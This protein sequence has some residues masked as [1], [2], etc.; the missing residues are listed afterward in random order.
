M[1]RDFFKF[2][3]LILLF[4]V[5]IIFNNHSHSTIILSFILHHSPRHVFL[6]PLPMSI[7]CNYPI[8]AISINLKIKKIFIIQEA[9][10][11]STTTLGG[12]F[13]AGVNDTEVYGPR[14]RWL[15]NKTWRQ[16]TR[17]TVALKSLSHDIRT[18][19]DMSFYLELSLS[20][21]RCVVQF[22]KLC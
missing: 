18:K 9:S 2:G 14:G 12:E 5:F 22:L 4:F 20:S 11:I 6:Y 17:K 8:S 21:K 15:M 7:F 13:T 16:K 3:G 1:S 19:S 10:K